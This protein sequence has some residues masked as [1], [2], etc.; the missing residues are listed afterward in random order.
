MISEAVRDLISGK[1]SSLAKLKLI[2]S[3]NLRCLSRL[4]AAVAPFHRV[5]SAEAG[6]AHIALMK[7]KWAQLGTKFE[8]ILQGDPPFYIH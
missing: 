8:A 3:F 5:K 7:E 6:A 4:V 2:Y 1:G